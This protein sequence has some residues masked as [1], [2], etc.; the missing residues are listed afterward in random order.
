M[1]IKETLYRNRRDFKA[2]FECEHCGEITERWGYDDA[3]FHNSVIPEIECPKCG[4]KASDDYKPIIP[5][6]PEGQV[7]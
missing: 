5:R 6:Y 1:K 3:Y 7:V 2:L 4:L